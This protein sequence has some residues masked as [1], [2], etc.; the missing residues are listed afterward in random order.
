MS[1]KTN[2]SFLFQIRANIQPTT[3]AAATVTQSTDSP[4]AEHARETEVQFDNLCDA[5]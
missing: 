4:A 1:I 2:S 3:G 5:A